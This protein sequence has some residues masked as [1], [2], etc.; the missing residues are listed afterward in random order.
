MVVSSEK[1]IGLAIA[2]LSH[3]RAAKFAA[4]NHQGFFQEAPLLQ[5]EKECGDGFIGFS[6]FIDQAKIK[7]STRLGAV[8]I[9]APVK[10]LHETHAF[11]H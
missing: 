5:V 6:A 7:G 4:P 11:F 1:F 2:V 9:P 3:W 8:G 10:Q